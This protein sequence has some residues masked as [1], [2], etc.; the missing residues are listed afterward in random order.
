VGGGAA[1]RSATWL[2]LMR[3]DHVAIPYAYVRRT[4]TNLDV[5]APALDMARLTR[6]AEEPDPYVDRA[7]SRFFEFD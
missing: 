4:A 7:A 3:S 6:L 1:R 2:R 5:R